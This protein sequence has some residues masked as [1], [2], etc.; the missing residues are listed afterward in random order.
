M[1][2]MFVPSIRLVPAIFFKAASSQL[3]Y[4]SNT[5]LFTNS[6]RMAMIMIPKK[7]KN[8][9]QTTSTTTDEG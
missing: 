1:T 9:G 8:L 4:L 7:E 3:V 6:T 5:L 2:N